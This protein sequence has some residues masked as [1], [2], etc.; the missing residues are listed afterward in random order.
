MVRPLSIVSL[1]F[2]SASAHA[3][4]DLTP[5]GS[6]TIGGQRVTCHADG[7]GGDNS[8]WAICD[9]YDV[10]GGGTDG[11]PV[12]RVDYGRARFQVP[13]G[14]SMQS[15]GKKACADVTCLVW[16]NVDNCTML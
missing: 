13:A 3:D 11:T 5:G 9:C 14:S 2:L 12:H 16:I 15:S 4:I 6:A 1:F 7:G 10:Q 8:R